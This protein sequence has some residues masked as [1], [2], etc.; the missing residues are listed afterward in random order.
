MV[1]SGLSPDGSLVEM[2]ELPQHPFFVASQFHPEFRSR[3]TDC[4]PLFRGFVKA[5]SEARK[6]APAEQQPL[7]GEL[8]IVKG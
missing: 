5:A 8:K 2:V 1:F 4:H 3:P 7:L 6:N